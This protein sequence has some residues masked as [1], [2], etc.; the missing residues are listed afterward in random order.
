MAKVYGKRA[1]ATPAPSTASTPTGTPPSSLSVS[2][3]IRGRGR[4]RRQP[5][6]DSEMAGVAAALF[7]LMEPTIATMMARTPSSS[8]DAPA[9]PAALPPA[10]SGSSIG[11]PTQQLQ[12]LLERAIK[13]RFEAFEEHIKKFEPMGGVVVERVAKNLDETLKRVMYERS[14]MQMSDKKR[15]RALKKAFLTA[16]IRNDHAHVFSNLMISTTDK[17]KAQGDTVTP[18]FP[19]GRALLETSAKERLQ[20]ICL[21]VP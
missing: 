12:A 21:A 11:V 15:D 6:T 14:A 5:L 16:A 1:R 8:P 10:S 17:P 4:T 13:E 2:T 3:P 18:C 19:Q 9:A 7:R 20:Q